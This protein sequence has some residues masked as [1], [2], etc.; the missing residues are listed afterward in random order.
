MY[1]LL[2]KPLLV[3]YDKHFDRFY[4]ITLPQ[5]FQVLKKLILILRAASISQG[6]LRIK[7]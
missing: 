2:V 1:I 6:F 4:H 3:R 7:L 5:L